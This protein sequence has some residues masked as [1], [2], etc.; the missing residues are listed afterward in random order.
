MI[1]SVSSGWL[2]KCIYPSSEAPA[3]TMVQ[4]ALVNGIGKE[5]SLPDF[6][7]LALVCKAWQKMIQPNIEKKLWKWSRLEKTNG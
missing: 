7:A 4:D 6:A 2:Q 1:N 3:Q 5:L